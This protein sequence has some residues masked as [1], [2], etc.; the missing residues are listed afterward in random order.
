MDARELVEWAV[1]VVELNIPAS[2]GPETGRNQFLSA[3]REWL[4]PVPAPVVVKRSWDQTARKLRRQLK[5][6]GFV[7]SDRSANP[8]TEGVVISRV[9]CSNLLSVTYHRE[10]RASSGDELLRTLI[11]T[12]KLRKWLPANG[13]ELDSLGYVVCGV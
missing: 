7:M 2:S 12:N 10:G 4:G 13:Y 3:A 8:W 11:Q 9:G 5:N 6:A 1:K